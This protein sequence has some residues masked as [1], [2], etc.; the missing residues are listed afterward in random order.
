MV[1]EAWSGNDQCQFDVSP[2]EENEIYPV[3][4]SWVASMSLEEYFTQDHRQCDQLFLAV[5]QAAEARDWAGIGKHAK[6]F[7]DRLE[8]HFQMEEGDLFPAFEEATGMRFGP[9]QVMRMEHQQMRQLLV[10]LQET[11]RDRDPEAILGV[12]ETLL[13]L[14]QQHNAK[15][16][17]MLYP[18]A[19]QALGEEGSAMLERLGP[20]PD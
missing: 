16:E 13:M 12:T 2:S 7:C 11:V 3:I 6:V 4:T 19:E 15:E 1:G 20:L 9:T 5:E 17:G 18:M 8:R 14:M 10:E